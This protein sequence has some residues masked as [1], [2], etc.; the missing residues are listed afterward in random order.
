MT[1]KFF[2]FVH[3]GPSVTSAMGVRFARQEVS[4]AVEQLQ[5]VQHSAM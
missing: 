4:W 1:G 3:N 2:L 5:S